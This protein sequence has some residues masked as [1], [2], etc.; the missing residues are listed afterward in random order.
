VAVV[1]SLLGLNVSSFPVPLIG[2]GFSGWHCLDGLISPLCAKVAVST[3]SDRVWGETSIW[4]LKRLIGGG[5]EDSGPLCLMVRDHL[6]AQ[7]CFSLFPLV[8]L[9]DMSAL[10]SN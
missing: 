9:F 2:A 4:G 1:P 10:L 5:G 8:L 6:Q 3:R 7:C